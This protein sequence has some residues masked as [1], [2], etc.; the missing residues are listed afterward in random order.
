MS[1][2]EKIKPLL[3]KG[4]PENIHNGLH[5]LLKG[6]QAVPFATGLV[7]SYFSYP[8]SLLEQ[9]LFGLKFT[10]PFGLAG[11]FDKNA[12]IL[13]A[14][15]ALGFGFLEVGSVTNSSSQGND[16]PRLFRLEEDQA[17]INRMGLNNVG[18]QEFLKNFH[19]NQIDKP[20]FI[21]ITKTNNPNLNGDQAIQ[22]IK[23]CYEVVGSS[24]KVLVLN[25]SCPNTK[26]GKTFEDLG[27]LKALLTAISE[28][29]KALALNHDI[30]I[31]L[32]N[33]IPLENLNGL[34][35][36]CAS[37]EVQGYI[38]SNTSVARS[39]LRASTD[40]IEAIG[41]GGLSGKPVFER[42]LERVRRVYEITEGKLPIVGVGGISST[43]DAIRML[44]AGASLLEIYTA[45]IYEGPGL[46][47][48]LCEG[49]EREMIK[50][51][52]LSLA[53]FRS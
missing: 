12:E 14:M 47:N 37:F 4:D 8:S 36:L 10:N 31:K 13:K 2:Y 27:S 35:E 18:A 6:V 30:L 20:V 24:A 17:L 34:I 50:R 45:L 28:S 1:I 41:R 40:R 29:R 51:G 53:E 25:L 49:V 22:D 5:S 11:G 9:D 26:D 38:V 21:N 23:E 42:A 16:K 32:S 43:E 15:S 7:E 52:Y 39:E 3:F 19:K 48:R 46:I 33:D 44:E